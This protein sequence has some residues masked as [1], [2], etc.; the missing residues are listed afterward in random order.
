MNGSTGT[1]PVA[2]FAAADI[3]YEGVAV[4]TGLDLEIDAGE[5][6]GLLGPNGSGKSTLVRG[7]LGLAPLLGGSLRLFGEDRQR[8]RD[9]R[10]IGYV[11][12]RQTVTGGVPST[13]RE[14]VTSGRLT[15]V[16]PFRPFRAADRAA[17]SRAI[18]AVGLADRTGEP[19]ATLSGGQQRRALIARA[20]AS[21]PDLLVL[22]EPTAGVDAAN[23][24][25]LARTL[26][27]LAAAGTTILLITHELGPAAP[28]IT[29]TLA[30]RDGRIVYDGPAQGAPDEHDDHWHHVHGDPP[31]RGP[32]LGLS[33]IGS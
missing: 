10:R 19:I 32:D 20:L 18:E 15:R 7:L 11:P 31:G 12:Q 4:V 16:R 14:V 5:V 27:D 24:Q 22:D 1:E 21:E 25:A 26:G 17:V 13:V 28:V 8:F 33:G 30:L 29:R 2:A 9:W 3:G 23:Q 6:V